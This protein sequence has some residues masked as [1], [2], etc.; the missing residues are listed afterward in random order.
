[1]SLAAVL[2]GIAFDP[3]IRGILVVLTGVTVLMGSVWLLVTTN[4]GARL[5]TLIALSAFFGWMFIMGVIWWIYGIGW[6]GDAPSWEPIDINQGC[7]AGAEPS[8]TSD[9]G[10]TV[11]GLDQARR[12]VDPTTLPNAY[13]IIVASDSELAKTDFASP[14]DPSALAGLSPE[15]AAKAEAAWDERNRSTT[16]S[17]L[18]SVDPSLTKP[19]D[20]GDGWRLLNT[21]QSGEAVATASAVLVER[22]DFGSV[23]EF[24]ILNSFDIGGK[25]RLPDDPNRWDR[26]ARKARTISQV[27]SP[28]H[29]TVVQVQ[30]VI[31]QPTEPGKAPPRP[32]VDEEAPIYSVVMERNLGNR[33][34]F[35]FL[36]ALGSLLLF[37][38]S[39]TMLHYRDKEA[40]ARRRA[41][42]GAK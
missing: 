37:T 19:I 14:L 42:T 8:A 38:V 26:I 25:V 3:T 32:K 41:T 30:A 24:K 9:C 4:V 11:S 36:T 16:L 22:G 20:V 13:D 21:A 18:A 40:M 28:P 7:I 6:I 34:L 35:P 23:G 12:L 1:M 31:D 10:L 29:Y 2:A 33:R 17:E 39:T 27:F 5:G 15:E